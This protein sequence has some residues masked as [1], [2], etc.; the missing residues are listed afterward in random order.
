MKK[1]PQDGE[2]SAAAA[3]A[4]KLIARAKAALSESLGY[5]EDQAHKYIEK[6]AMNERKRRDE[7]AMEI[8]KTYG[9]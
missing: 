6:R 1:T 2:R 4:R 8:L 3:E 7:I 9:I 5:T